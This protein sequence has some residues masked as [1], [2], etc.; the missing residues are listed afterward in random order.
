MRLTFH[1]AVRTVTGSLHQVEV[2]GSLLY[3]DCGLY[4]GRRA[5]AYDR[6]RRFPSTQRDVEA[7][8]LSHAHLDHCGNLPTLVAGGF[9]GPIYC[10][11]A[12]RDLAAL[13]L[14]DSAK[15]ARQ[16]VRIVNTIRR[17]QGLPAV[18]VLYDLHAAERAIAQMVPVG[19]GR[20]FRAG[21]A[22]ATLVDAGHILGSAMVLLEGDGRRLGFSGDLSRAGSPIVRDPEVLPGID[23][24]L[25]ESTY[26]DHQHGSLAEAEARLV[27]VI[28]ETVRRGGRVLIPAFALGR[29]QQIIYSLFRHRVAGR[30][31]DV[32]LYVDSPMAIDATTVY[33]RHPEC[34]DP[35]ER[36]LLK[37]RDP[38]GLKGARYVRGARESQVLVDSDE[39]CVVIAGSGMLEGGRIRL[40][41]RRRIGDPQS[42]LLLVGYQA[43]HTL[44]RKLVDGATEVRIYGEPYQVA[45]QVARIDAFSAHADRNEL[46]A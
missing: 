26:G 5:E 12:T 20:R 39:P 30:I 9:R 25:I 27:A 18:D 42:T 2:G 34:F 37:G 16:D 8:I 11:P 44:G 19:Y 32:P 35:A 17:R 15:V 7:V 10:T 13:V 38:L 4:Q 14:R 6:N 29:T 23:L 22:F 41:V 3:L 21:P 40:H 28:T 36:A 45:I 46:L 43:E 24:L 33:R 31:P 1:G